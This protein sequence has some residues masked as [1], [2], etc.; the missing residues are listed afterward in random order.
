MI[1]QRIHSADDPLF[2]PFWELYERAFPSDERRGFQAQCSLFPRREYRL[3]AIHD[4]G[5][6]V[7]FLSLWSLQERDFIE[8]FAIIPSLQGKGYGSRI[9]KDQILRSARPIVIEVEPP[10]DDAKKRRIA[11]YER[12]GFILCPEEYIQPPYSSDKKP[13]RMRLMSHPD[14][15]GPRAFPKARAVLHLQVY[16][17]SEPMISLGPKSEL[18]ELHAEDDDQ[19]D[20]V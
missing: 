9:I 16:G 6:F 19:V 5:S 13:V 12:L 7:G 14:K 17:L 3:F 1:L 11:F 20:S 10:E 4:Q 8:H 15:L 2:P 18:L